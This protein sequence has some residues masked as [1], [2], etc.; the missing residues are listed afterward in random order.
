MGIS[1]WAFMAS[2]G[3]AGPEARRG[4]LG[5]RSPALRHL[6]VELGEVGGEGAVVEVTGPSGQASWRGSVHLHHR[7]IVRPPR[8]RPR[9]TGTST[10]LMAGIELTVRR[11]QE[12]GGRRPSV[13][14]GGTRWAAPGT[15]GGHVGDSRRHGAHSTSAG[16]SRRASGRAVPAMTIASSP[17][18][19]TADPRAA[20]RGG[21]AVRPREPPRPARA[22][23]VP[24]SAGVHSRRDV[25]PVGR[26]YQTR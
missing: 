12:D 14:A 9:R 24:D 21:R 17:L 25:D 18:V 26:A 15:R 19:I 23:R 10:S 5:R 20:Y 3:E 2:I 4:R 7:A 13:A 6:V 8:R 22:R 16:R 1:T 11:D